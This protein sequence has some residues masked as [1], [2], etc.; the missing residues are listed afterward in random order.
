MIE[1]LQTPKPR[2]FQNRLAP[3]GPANSLKASSPARPWS[4]GKEIDFYSAGLEWRRSSGS[5]LDLLVVGDISFSELLEALSDAES[6]LRR[7]IPP[8]LFSVDEFR[9]RLASKDHFLDSVPRRG[10]GH[11][12]RCRR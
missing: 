3:A 1:P 7:E 2:S 11:R 12:D 10:E 8:S 6:K 5:D 9:S 4:N